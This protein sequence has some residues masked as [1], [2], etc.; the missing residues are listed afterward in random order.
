MSSSC[1]YVVVLE[2][3]EDDDDVLSC[4]LYFLSGAY[5]SPLSDPESV[6][7]FPTGGSISGYP[8]PV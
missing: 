5:V 3:E 6:L 4:V 7:I 2:E 8:I 1:S